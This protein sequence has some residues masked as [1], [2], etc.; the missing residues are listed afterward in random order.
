MGKKGTFEVYEEEYFL[1]CPNNQSYDADEEEP[2]I[3]NGFYLLDE[4]AHEHT[5]ESLDE[6]KQALIA[7][8]W[9]ER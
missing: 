1:F 6:A 4:Y 3:P 2:D 5:F 7:Y 8:G 9:T